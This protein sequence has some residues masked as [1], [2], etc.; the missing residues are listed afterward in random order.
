MSE[1]ELNGASG[2]IAER[3]VG[4]RS[5]LAAARPAREGVPDPEL[6]ER[7]KRRRFT[8]E[9]KL[10]IL[11]QAEACTRPGEIGVLLRREGLYTSHLTAW[12]K[13]RDAGA[14]EALDRPRGRKPADPRDVENAAL[15][16]RLERA[17]AE[18]VKARKVIEVQG[19]VS[20]L[21]GELLEPRGAIEPGSSGR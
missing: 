3:A 16:R 8:A 20:A 13:Q 14:L 21:L 9:Y 6:V 5:D 1:N 4:E 11:R 17:E 2:R 12:R 18:L 10:R 7:A 19:N 15:R